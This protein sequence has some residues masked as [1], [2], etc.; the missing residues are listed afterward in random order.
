MLCLPSE[1]IF[2]SGIQNLHISLQQGP[3]IYNITLYIRSM[4]RRQV[5]PRCQW[6][7]HNCDFDLFGVLYYSVTFDD[8]SVGIT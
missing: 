3:Y 2:L 8:V 5:C 7:T 1:V 4:I 6:W